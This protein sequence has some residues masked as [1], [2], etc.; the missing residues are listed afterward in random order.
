MLHKPL[1]CSLLLPFN[2]ALGDFKS[3]KISNID[4]KEKNV[5]ELVAARKA[6]TRS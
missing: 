5:F 4:M 6:S 2:D 1:F 3:I